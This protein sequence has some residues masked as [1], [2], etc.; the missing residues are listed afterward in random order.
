MLYA[1]GPFKTALSQGANHV[2]C[3]GR[4]YFWN[5]K[6]YFKEL[7]ERRDQ[8]VDDVSGRKI[9]R[10]IRF[11]ENV[12]K[13]A[14]GTW[15]KN[16]RYVTTRTYIIPAIVSYRMNLVQ[17]NIEVP[18][19][20]RKETLATVG[21][22]EV[23]EGTS[24]SEAGLHWRNKLAWLPTSVSRLNMRHAWESNSST[25]GAEPRKKPSFVV[26]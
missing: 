2:Q 1:Y 5:Y 12:H 20:R 17:R 18:A 14:M 11:T 6:K 15:E 16:I 10:L 3:K 13:C 8:R 23:Y 25:D 21:A 7:S 22:Q 26:I 19:R 9:K 4:A 24:A